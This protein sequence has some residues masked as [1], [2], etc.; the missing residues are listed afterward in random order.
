MKLSTTF[1]MSA[2]LVSFWV[3]PTAAS[4]QENAC[5]SQSDQVIVRFTY[6]SEKSTWIYD[7]TEQFNKEEFKTASDKTICV[8][9]IPKGSGDSVNEIKNGQA[10]VN[11]VHATSPA[12]DLYVNLINYESNEEKGKDLLKTP[13]FSSFITCRDRC[14]GNNHTQIRQRR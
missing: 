10:G 3:A 5:S 2:V 6:G 14:M 11:E 12:S 1:Y 4:K 8:H 7:V 13:G 9:A